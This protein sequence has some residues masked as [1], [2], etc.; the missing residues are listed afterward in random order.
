METRSRGV[1]ALYESGFTI[2]QVVGRIGYSCSLIRK[3]LHENG[4]A[5]RATFIGKRA[6]PWRIRIG[7]SFLLSSAPSCAAW[8]GPVSRPPAH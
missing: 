1:A 5:K 2:A 6:A 3:V 7:S 4:V 8:W